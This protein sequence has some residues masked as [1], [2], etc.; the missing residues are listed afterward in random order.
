M[1][2]NLIDGNILEGSAVE[3]GIQFLEDVDLM[4]GPGREA[5]VSNLG[6][7]IRGNIIRSHNENAIDLKGAARVVID[8][9]LIYGIVGSSNGPRLGW[10]RNAHGSITRGNNTSTRDVIIRR[11]II[12]DSAPGI[13]AHQGY[14]IY[15]NTLVANNRDYTGPNSEWTAEGRPAFSGIRQ[16][17]PGDGGIAIQNNILVGHNTVEVAL[18]LLKNQAEPNHIDS[19]LYYNSRGVYFAHVR[20][21]G[22]WEVLTLSMW[23]RLLEG[24]DTITGKEQSSFVADPLFVDAPE[25]PLSG[26]SGLDFNLRS[27]S[28][29][30]DRGGP[31]TWTN[32]Q[33]S[34]K[35]IALDDAGYFSTGYGVVEGDLIQVGK[36]RPARVTAIDYERDVV[37]VDRSLWWQDAAPVSLAYNGSAPDIGALECQE[38]CMSSP[39]IPIPSNRV[40]RGLRALYTFEDGYGTQVRDVSGVGT[41][42]HL[43]VQDRSAV[44]WASHFLT[45]RAPT[46]ISSAGPANKIT[47]ACQASNE[48]TLEAWVSPADTESEGLARIVTLSPDAD[49]VNFALALGLPAQEPKDLYGMRLRT[50]EQT[51]IGEPSL[52]SLR[53]VALKAPTHVVF[54]RESSGTARIYVNN[55]LHLREEVGGDFS[56]WDDRYPLTV[57]NEATGGHPWLGK[58]YLVA[59]YC[60]AL[61]SHEVWQNYAFGL[62]DVYRPG[63]YLPQVVK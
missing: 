58:L 56:N 42:L 9:N 52:S 25:K 47:K 26:D 23:Q 36:N 27:G 37:T 40:T 38:D 51:N 62:N 55:E 22:D 7:V 43:R 1:Q 32:G 28:P 59:V 30:I 53:G 60:R 5:D 12:Y 39:P 2:G 24:F 17:E 54:T 3:D 44:Y 15:H 8:G 11:N 18:Y 34:G 31:L 20:P 4:P 6:T 45:V 21:T 35:E 19:N 10:N 33:G 13:R 57:G 16:K 63:Y 48:L 49:N 61:D 14:K 29:A 41:P 50:S 46:L